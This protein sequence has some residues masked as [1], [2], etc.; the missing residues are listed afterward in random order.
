M[1]RLWALAA[2]A[3]AAL[4]IGAGTA[5]VYLVTGGVEVLG[6]HRPR[7]TSLLDSSQATA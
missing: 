5:T 4:A 1:Y 2:F 3:Q 6:G 7:K